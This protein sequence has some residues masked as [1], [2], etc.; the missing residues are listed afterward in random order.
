MRKSLIVRAVAGALLLATIGV[1]SFNTEAA[2]ASEKIKVTALVTIN[3]HDRQFDNRLKACQDT[4]TEATLDLAAKLYRQTPSE[5]ARNIS[6][7]DMQYDTNMC[8]IKAI[9]NKPLSGTAY[10]QVRQGSEWL[11]FWLIDWPRKIYKSS[12]H[13]KFTPE[14]NHG[15][16]TGKTTYMLYSKNTADSAGRQVVVPD[17]G[18]PSRNL[19]EGESCYDTSIT[20]VELRVRV[21][22]GT[23]QYF[24]N[25][26]Q[27]FYVNSDKI[28]KRGNTCE[29]DTSP[30]SSGKSPGQGSTSGASGTSLPQCS[31]AQI[32]EHSTLAKDFNEWRS[33]YLDSIN[34][35]EESIVGMNKAN[36]TGNNAAY[37]GWAQNL[38]DSKELARST[39]TSAI[40]TQ[41]KLIAL[42]KQCSFNYGIIV[43][44]PYGFITTDEKFRGY[45]FPTFIIP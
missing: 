5:L 19:I 31:V 17:P 35:I 26:V 9:S 1:L 20:N 10:L 37:S 16:I 27:I 13:H 7:G 18:R 11:D 25:S 30:S 39:A 14:Y 40:D 28:I 6:E 15:K 3:F 34:L 33:M 44:Q 2:V 43:T 29:L 41:N 21:T 4:F 36:M 32:R 22:S 24:S 38:R 45:R 42:M 12:L 8:S 23:K